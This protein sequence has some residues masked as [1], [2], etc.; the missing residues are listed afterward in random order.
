MNNEEVITKLK[1]IRKELGGGLTTYKEMAFF[2]RIKPKEV[3]CWNNTRWEKS[4]LAG[5]EEQF[6]VIHRKRKI[7]AK[8]YDKGEL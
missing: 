6:I 7:N 3:I 2:E 1:Y 8:Q 4:E 5:Y